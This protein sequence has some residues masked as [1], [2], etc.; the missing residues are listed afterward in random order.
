MGDL[1]VITWRDM[2]V[3]GAAFSAVIPASWFIFHAIKKQFEKQTDR[4]DRE[5]KEQATQAE[6][7]T[8]RTHD[9]IENLGREIR[10]TFVPRD[11]FNVE[12]RR[13]DQALD[14]RDRQMNDFADRLRN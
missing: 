4:F 3:I 8:R 1:G 12:I 6:E 5:F 9:S 7:R 14:E 2:T 10:E 13:L 11:L